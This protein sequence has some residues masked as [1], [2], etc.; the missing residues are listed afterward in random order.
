MFREYL[1]PPFKANTHFIVANGLVLKCYFLVVGSASPGDQSIPCTHPFSPLSAL[2]GIMFSLCI[3]HVTF[4][5]VHSHV[6]LVCECSLFCTQES[7]IIAFFHVLYVLQII[8]HLLFFA[9]KSFFAT[10]FI[11]P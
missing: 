1:S 8:S 3:F 7:E 4:S 10:E 2:L 11:I 5:C 9:L 6:G